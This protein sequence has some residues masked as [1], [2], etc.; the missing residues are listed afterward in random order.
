MTFVIFLNA[1]KCSGPSWCFQASNAKLNYN[2][3]SVRTSRVM[4]IG[5]DA[6]PAFWVSN[7]K[8]VLPTSYIKFSFW[9]GIY[10]KFRV[11]YDFPH[12]NWY[13]YVEL[14][15][16]TWNTGRHS[17]T[18]VSDR[19]W[20]DTKKSIL[21]RKNHACMIQNSTWIPNVKSYTAKSPRSL[22]IRKSK[23]IE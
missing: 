19:Q 9:F 2:I 14:P 3:S 5:C 10:F 4:E 18:K 16:P 21:I 12:Q 1:H 22:Q 20:P 6:Q 11:M 8:F 13:F 17:M 15:G 7:P 23:Y